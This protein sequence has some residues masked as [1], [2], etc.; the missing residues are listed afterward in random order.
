MIMLSTVISTAILSTAMFQP[1]NDTA[2]VQPKHLLPSPSSMYSKDSID[3]VAWPKRHIYLYSPKEE[4]GR[5]PV[6]FFC[7]G[8]TA[9]DPSCYEALIRHI[10]SRGFAVIYSPYPA[11]GAYFFPLHTYRT[12]WRGF[13]AGVASWGYMLDLN[14]IAFV[15]HSYGAGA[16]PKLAQK[17]ISDKQWGSTA[18]F[19]Y[20]MAPWYVHGITPRQLRHYPRNVRM[21]IQVFRDD[22]INDHRIAKDLY[23]SIGIPEHKKVFCE[24]SGNTAASQLIADHDVPLGSAGYSLDVD[25]LDY[26][27]IHFVFDAL[28]NAP[29]DTT[30]PPSTFF[31][32]GRAVYSLVGPSGATCRLAVDP[33]PQMVR[34]QN[35]CVN[36]WSHAMNPRRN[37]YRFLGKPARMVLTTPETVLKYGSLALR[38]IVKTM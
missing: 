1:N 19:L 25:D 30:V 2:L 17:A 26:C 4:G 11:A 3:H 28:I 32:G 5:F 12:I 6:V 23:S 22:I 13:E 31:T 21:V 18:I 16:I 35:V 38:V 8:I 36:F 15:G 24:L 20:L 9:S 33:D 37:G 14:T 10:V 29:T 34:T 7:H 27:G